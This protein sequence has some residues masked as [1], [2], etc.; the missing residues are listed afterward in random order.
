MII[1]FIITTY[2]NCFIFCSTQYEH[3]HIVF[4]FQKSTHVYSNFTY[5]IVSSNIS[6]GTPPQ[7]IQVS[8]SSQL[9]LSFIFDKE[10]NGNGFS[11]LTSKSFSS[12]DE[13]IVSL[14]FRELFH[15]V[16]LSYDLI[17]IPNERSSYEIITFPFYYDLTYNNFDYNGGIIGVNIGKDKVSP[18][19]KEMNSLL[20]VLY[21]EQHV[22]SE[23]VSIDYNKEVIVFGKDIK[24]RKEKLKM[25]CNCNESKWMC[26]IH[27][28]NGIGILGNESQNDA[29]KV[30]FM[31]ES[32]FSLCPERYFNYI[33]EV[34]L[35]HE[36]NKQ[37]CKV[38]LTEYNQQYYIICNHN[39]NINQLPSL[40]FEFNNKTNTL[41]LSPQELFINKD[42]NFI[43]LFRY[44]IN[45]KHWIFGYSF[46]TT[47]KTT[48][49]YD[50]HTKH[51][52]IFNNEVLSS[53]QHHAI[54]LHL[55]KLIT[56]INTICLMLLL[57]Y[58]FKSHY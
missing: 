45:T 29:N 26:T 53:K 50:F 23:T 1:L 13:D 2:I 56:F 37:I 30:L 41:T 32:E 42:N 14:T 5:A 35:K 11:A 4:P 21:K 38:D 51:I 18:I 31:F 58:K 17:R 39:I 55:I 6:I 52:Y 57:I 49:H 16:K 3:K 25:K 8:F 7:Y 20:N 27:A 9:Y 54:I 47:T 24:E 36:F 28:L 19:K 22:S 34:Y 43:F 10:Y 15:Y 40:T 12:K 46:L 44:H 33:Q 48:I